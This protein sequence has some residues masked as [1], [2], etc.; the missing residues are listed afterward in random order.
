MPE[1]LEIVKDLGYEKIQGA[2]LYK[3]GTIEMSTI[4]MLD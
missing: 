4:E 1:V 2:I 3:D